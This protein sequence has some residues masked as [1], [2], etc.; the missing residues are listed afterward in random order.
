MCESHGPCSSED[1]ENQSECQELGEADPHL[2]PRKRFSIRLCCILKWP[3]LFL[4]SWFSRVPID[5]SD[6]GAEEAAPLCGQDR[7]WKPG[8]VAVSATFRTLL[9]Y[10]T[11]C[12]RCLL[13]CRYLIDHNETKL[14][15]LETGGQLLSV[16]TSQIEEG[17][18]NDVVG[19]T[20]STTVQRTNENHVILDVVESVERPI[21]SRVAT[22]EMIVNLG[23]P[24]EF[25]KLGGLSL[26][27][28]K[29]ITSSVCPELPSA[30]D[31][32]E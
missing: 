10:L 7:H 24:R 9:G 31:A 13:C 1:G 8:A 4:M 17:Q 23:G 26:W 15:P 25:V 3:M 27:G 12:C 14:N 32:F 20:N 11:R 28:Y 21:K 19:S 22:E 2:E 5:V 6:V 18:V 30:D 29:L 16:I